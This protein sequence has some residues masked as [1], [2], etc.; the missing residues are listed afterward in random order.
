MQ[1]SYPH[2][3]PIDRGEPQQ[4]KAC[5]SRGNLPLE[6]LLAEHRPDEISPL[7]EVG[8][9]THIRGVTKSWTHRSRFA[10]LRERDICGIHGIPLVSPGTDIYAEIGAGP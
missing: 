5:R 9:S 6:W 3:G 2:A 4:K 10:P 7:L 8:G 1:R